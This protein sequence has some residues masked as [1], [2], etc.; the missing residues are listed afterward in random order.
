MTRTLVVPLDGSPLAERA[1][2]YALSLAAAQQSRVV[3]LRVALANAPMTIDGS[4]WERD[5]LDAIA[6]A[7]RYLETVSEG[8]PAGVEVATEVPYGPAARQILAALRRLHADGVVMAT[9]GR[10][11]L[12]HL[13][14]GS[15][16]EAILAGSH[17]PVFLVHAQPAHAQPIPF[18]ASALRVLVPLDGSALTETAIPIA[19]DYLTPQTGGS[20]LQ[21]T[22]VTEPNPVQYDEHGGVLAYLDQQEEALT[23]GARDY[24]DEAA[25]RLHHTAPRL[26]VSTDVR[27]GLADEV[28]ASLANAHQANLIVMATHA[29][30]G[31]QRARLGSVAGAV[32]RATNTPVVLVHPQAQEPGAATA[33]ATSGIERS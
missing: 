1:L 32:L 15:V 3:L 2:P 20:L 8:L 18:D 27:I 30:T 16:A 19:I 29:R 12:A 25:R 9:H 28:I 5:Q 10:T 21:A 13:L 22:A 4:D 6:E 17:V 24:L 26:S 14:H 33:Y 31:L 7:E 11:G 23:R